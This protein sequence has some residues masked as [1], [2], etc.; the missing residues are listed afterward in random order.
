MA[1]KKNFKKVPLEV[2][3]MVCFPNGDVAEATAYRHKVDDELYFH[4]LVLDS[5][6]CGCCAGGNP[7]PIAWDHKPKPPTWMEEKS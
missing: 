3:I 2:D 5:H 6:G 1:W 4:P 7:D